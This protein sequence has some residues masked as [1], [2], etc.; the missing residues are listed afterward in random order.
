[1]ILHPSIVFQLNTTSTLPL[2]FYVV[3]SDDD[4][5]DDDDDDDAV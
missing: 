1:M 3:C 2:T 5:D 4:G